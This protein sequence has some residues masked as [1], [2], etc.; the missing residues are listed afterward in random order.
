MK[1]LG[2]FLTKGPVQAV[3]GL[4]CLSGLA[5]IFP[6]LVYW[7]AGTP[8]ALIGLRQGWQ[9]TL[10]LLFATVV[11]VVVLLMISGVKP[12]YIVQ[13][14]LGVWVSVSVAAAVLRGTESQGMMVASAAVLALLF[15]LFMHYS[16]PDLTQYYRDL[17][18]EVW[19][20]HIEPGLSQQRSAEEVSSLKAVADK[21]VPLLNGV[22]ASFIVF[23]IV[24][25]VLLARAWQSQLFN[26]GGFWKEFLQLRLP[27]WL[28]VMMMIAAVAV[29]TQPGAN[30]SIA[31]DSLMVLVMAYAFQGLVTVHAIVDKKPTMKPWLVAMYFSLLF[32]T[33]YA[34]ILL[35]CIGVVDSVLRRGN[36][37]GSA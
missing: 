24:S 22:R 14:L 35:C 29:I 27:R 19:F 11:M 30:D 13:F 8:M 7:L 18:D 33:L 15:V 10:S 21:M 36:P 25:A 23:G 28:L 1:T 9:R 2:K 26:P 5:A 32:V 34:L 12:Y 17:F 3:C 6:P 37:Q 31:R 4:T 16:Q 20:K